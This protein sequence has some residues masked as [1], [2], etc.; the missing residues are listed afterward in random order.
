MAPFKPRSGHNLWYQYDAYEKCRSE[1][2]L[3][4]EDI[5]KLR[6]A[7]RCSLAHELL[8]PIDALLAPIEARGFLEEGRGRE[9]YLLEE[10][11][12][13]HLIV[14]R[15]THWDGGLRHRMLI[16][17][18]WSSRRL[19]MD[20]GH[21]QRLL[22]EAEEVIRVK[23]IEEWGDTY[24]R[25]ASPSILTCMGEISRSCELL[26]VEGYNDAACPIKVEYQIVIGAAPGV[27]AFYNPE[28]YSTVLEVYR[29]LGREPLELRARDVIP[30]LKPEGFVEISPLKRAELEDYD[31]L[32]EKLSP[33]VEATLM[34][35][36]PGL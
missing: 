22:A 27:A 24:R 34:S 19:L 5:I 14:E 12:Y 15:Y 29:S 21:L 26:V 25:L 31:R 6:A 11:T 7:S 1:G 17:E 2:R 13:S 33:L 18:R 8:N 36:E 16:N 20:E 3:Y 9:I 4:C 23:S 10:D 30:F 32:S 35:V 28:E